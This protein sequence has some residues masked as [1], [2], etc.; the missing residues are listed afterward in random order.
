MKYNLLWIITRGQFSDQNKITT[1][2]CMQSYWYVYIII[3][4][5]HYDPIV[6]FATRKSYFHILLGRSIYS[7]RTI[8]INLN[9]FLII[10]HHKSITKKH[11][12]QHWTTGVWQIAR[13]DFFSVGAFT[14]HHLKRSCQNKLLLLHISLFLISC[15]NPH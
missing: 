14:F 4:L 1:C 12:L 3:I 6:N 8:N 5:D 9:Y 2:T 7:K 15:L 11:R 10:I 13:V